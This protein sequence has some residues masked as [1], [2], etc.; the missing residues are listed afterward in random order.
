[1]PYVAPD[2]HKLVNE[3]EFYE[4]KDDTEGSLE[5]RDETDKLLQPEHLLHKNPGLENTVIGKFLNKHFPPLYPHIRLS[6]EDD[7]SKALDN[8]D[9][10]IRK[11]VIKSPHATAEHI[12][13]ALN[14]PT[15]LVRA[16][17]IQHP[18][19]NEG[20]ITQALNDFGPNETYNGE[21]KKL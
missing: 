15:A 1:M 16:Q 7:V 4:N 3:D 20:H 21:L 9:P 5:I 11:W 2:I 17:A 8:P 13:K 12:T 10:L 18:N 14:D 6:S 19:V